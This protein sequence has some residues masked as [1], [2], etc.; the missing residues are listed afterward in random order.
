MGQQIFDADG[1]FTVPV[2]ISSV[3]LCMCGGGG[4]GAEISDGPDFVLGGGGLAGN[5]YSGVVGVIPGEDVVV[6]IGAGGPAVS[7]SV[8]AAGGTSSF[9]TYATAS[10][11]AG[12]AMSADSIPLYDGEG[13]SKTYCGG[14]YQD[15]TVNEEAAP[16][17][18]ALGGEAG[19]FGNGGQG[20]WENSY[21][22]GIGAGGGSAT[23]TTSG[24]GG[25]GRVAVNWDDEPTGVGEFR[26]NGT[27]IPESTGAIVIAENGG[28]AY[29]ID[30]LH[31]NGYVVWKRP[32]PD[33]TV[34][35][36]HDAISG[37]NPETVTG[38]EGVFNF[39]VPVDIVNI[40]LCITGAGGSGGAFV[41]G[42][43]PQEWGGENG[44]YDTRTIV[45]TA[46]EVIPITIG[47]GGAS[48]TGAFPGSSGN[49]GGASSIVAVNDSVN[50]GG[51]RGSGWAMGEYSGNGGNEITTCGGT[52]RD[53][54]HADYDGAGAWGGKAG[55]FGNGG[56]GGV[57]TG[58]AGVGGSGGGGSVSSGSATSGAGGDGRIVISWTGV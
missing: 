29:S 10:G 45:V 8:G 9:G 56:S 31:E 42:D 21:A 28:E 47:K 16:F 33:G 51:G 19:V 6:T 54:Y 52:F 44:A 12:G 50:V 5:E 24:A 18:I 30:E 25:H 49:A 53:G 34:T 35:I 17:Y 15:G 32:A 7:Q 57:T 38:A 2:G 13:E 1:T 20:G 4:S 26:M 39:T 37:L 46:G 40:S 58:S 22:G 27:I 55:C 48:V 41:S 23:N 14:T 11:G 36:D 43:S 3:T